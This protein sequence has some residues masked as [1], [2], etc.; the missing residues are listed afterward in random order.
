MENHPDYS[1]NSSQSGGAQGAPTNRQQQDEQLAMLVAAAQAAPQSPEQQ[2]NLAA[3]YVQYGCYAE[4][5]A[6]LD[7]AIELSPDEA[8]L[9][10][11][12]GDALCSLGRFN[13]ALAAAD[14]S[15]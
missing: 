3:A 2:F 1:S 8:L 15:I 5:L 4:S 6:P 13:E 7:R 12:K 14:Q 9:Y 11:M 10:Q